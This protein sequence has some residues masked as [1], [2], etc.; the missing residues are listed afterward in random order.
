MRFLW[1]HTT[2]DDDGYLIPT[3]ASIEPRGDTD[4]EVVPLFESQDQ[5][6]NTDW[7][8]ITRERFDWW[9]ASILGS[10]EDKQVD[11]SSVPEK[12]YVLSV[13][14]KDGY[15]IPIIAATD[16]SWLP[17]LFN[18]WKEYERRIGNLDFWRP[19]HWYVTCIGVA[20]CDQIQ[21]REVDKN[22]PRT[23]QAK[24]TSPTR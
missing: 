17:N 14:D 8:S 4:W 12:A 21:I 7:D 23:Y 16:E 22:A 11:T 10:L 2:F 18:S 15:Y 5:V 19:D 3:I 24:D 20:R 1:V 6:D 13:R 9:A